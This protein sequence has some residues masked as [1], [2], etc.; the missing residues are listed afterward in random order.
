MSKLVRFGV[1]LEKDF[2][3]KFDELIERE[4]YTNRSEAIRD[5][6]RERFAKREWECGRE[7]VGAITLVYD[8]HYSK[9]VQ[10]LM[11]IQHENPKII[12]TSHIHLSHDDCLEIIA[13]RDRS[14]NITALAHKLKSVKGVKQCD[15]AMCSLAKNM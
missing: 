15:L 12:S 5:L 4:G 3:G 6:I 13:V 2:L 11:D 7:V 1:S 9:V 14:K 8:H 10:T